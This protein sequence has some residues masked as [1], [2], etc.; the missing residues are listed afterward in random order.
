MINIRTLGINFKKMMSI[1]LSCIFIALILSGC[2][3]LQ[4][5][6]F[7]SAE[8][9]MKFD[10]TILFT[11]GV[12]GYTLYRIPGI[13]VT[14][15]GTVITYCEARAGRADRAPMDV[16]MRRSTDNG[17]SWESRVNLAEGIS[18]GSTMNNPVMIAEKDSGNVHFFY[19]KNYYQCFYRK[20]TDH[21]AT[22]SAPL[23]ITDV[24]NQYKPEYDWVAIAT[25]P[26]HGIELNNGRL[27]VPF[28]LSKS[29]SFGVS[30]VSTIY[31]DDGGISW[32]KGEI[33]RE[34]QSTIS[35]GEPVAVQRFDGSI[36]MNIR[37]GAANK[38]R[39]VSTSSNG[40]D[41]WTSPIFH[42]DLIDPGCFGSIV[43]LT[44]KN[45]YHNN[46]LLFSNVN[47]PNSR[48][49][50]TIKMSM[51][52]GETWQYSKVINKSGS[53]Y[54][55]I[56]VSKDKNSLFCFYEKWEGNASYKYLSLARFNLEWLTNGEQSLDPVSTP[57]PKFRQVPVPKIEKTWI[58]MSKWTNGGGGTKEIK[59]A[60][61]LHLHD[62][63]GT[64]AYVDFKN[65]S[66]PQ[67]YTI[68]FRAKIDDFSDENIMSL[69]YPTSFGIK[70][71][72]G[73][74]NL[75]LSFKNDGIYAV[76]NDD[77]WTKV[78]IMPLDNDW[79]TWKIKVN[80]G[81]AEVLMDGSSKCKFAMQSSNNPDLLQH[82]ILGTSSDEVR[83]HIEY[84][85][86]Y[87]DSLK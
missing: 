69:P 8:Q 9:S 17:E 16:I 33:I 63:S 75:L 44:D 6:Q 76:T 37:N 52:E 60:G 10:E 13:V 87:T 58:D 48:S 46:R 74:Y 32:N 19:N 20:S 15:N 12:D 81:V 50:L 30:A 47:N 61:Q 43:R 45:N 7:T 79:H 42:N 55:D 84:T 83:A 5:H 29:I 71:Q 70:I 25:G 31:S 21:G 73:V 82:W 53:G 39:T 23:E 72:D 64:G 40:I 34:T 41:G 14:S 78:K 11:S 57:T 4:K 35:L 59:P 66:I 38:L 27:I 28:W 54:S 2:N 18:S 24:F 51:D 68:E 62:N 3:N 1:G 65:M 86:L 56:A 22:W 85:K 80:H 49:N 36:L 67:S 26:G 77:K